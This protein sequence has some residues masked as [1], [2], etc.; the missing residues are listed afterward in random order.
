MVASAPPA[1][2][3]A[4]Q[5]RVVDVDE[6]VTVQSKDLALPGA[7]GRGELDPTA[8]PEPLGLFCHHD[9]RADARELGREQRALARS[10]REDHPGDTGVRQATDLVSGERLPGDLDERLRPSSGGLAEAL[11]LA[12][13]ENDRLHAGAQAS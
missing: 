8:A 1:L 12:A 7:E 13:G 11:G 4:E 5:A 6:L 10:A 2:C 9:L 3:A